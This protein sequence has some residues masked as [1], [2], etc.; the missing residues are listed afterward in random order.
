VGWNVASSAIILVVIISYPTGSRP[1]SFFHSRTV[2]QPISINRTLH[3]SKMFV[4]NIV[5]VISIYI[6]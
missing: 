5:A 3:I 6:L 2:W 1:F 4:I